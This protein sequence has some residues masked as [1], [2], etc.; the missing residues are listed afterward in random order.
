MTWDGNYKYD[1]AIEGPWTFKEKK[2]EVCKIEFS[3]SI[4]IGRQVSVRIS[5]KRA[6]SLIS[7]HGSI[8]INSLID[9]NGSN[10][11]YESLAGTRI[12]GYAKA[13]PDREHAGT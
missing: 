5:G 4:F 10:H 13:S 11:P 12:G 9:I 3:S 7:T 6:L 1:G 2:N 8:E